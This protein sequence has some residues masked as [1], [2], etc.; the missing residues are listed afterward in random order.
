[1]FHENLKV[2]KLKH[3]TPPIETAYLKM[4]E[5]AIKLAAS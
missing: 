3:I 2:W 1:M 4:Y 5:L